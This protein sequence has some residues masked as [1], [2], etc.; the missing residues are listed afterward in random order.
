MTS[1]DAGSVTLELVDGDGEEGFPGEVRVSVRY[2]VEGSE[3]SISAMATTTAPTVLTMTNHAYWNLGGG[4]LIDQHELTI[5][6]D[7]FVEVDS[8]G[9]PTGSFGHVEDGPIPLLV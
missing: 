7:R 3:L 5:D 9:I 1:R 8:T 6:A 2:A 4:G